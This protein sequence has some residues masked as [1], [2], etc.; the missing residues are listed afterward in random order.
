MLS[1]VTAGVAML[2]VMGPNSRA[3]LE[4]LS[5]ADLSNAAHPFG[6][7][8]EIEIG[9]ARVRASRITYI[10]ELG[11]E[12]YIPGE[13]VLDVYERVIEA[14]CGLRPPPARYHARAAPPG[15]EGHLRPGLAPACSW[16]P[17]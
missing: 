13:Q 10:G 2:G 7:S 6:Q 11:W 5:G 1:D 17:P 14:E 12:L 3:L 4:G 9:Y 8:R 15:G 16:T